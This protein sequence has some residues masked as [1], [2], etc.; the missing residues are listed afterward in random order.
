MLCGHDAQRKPVTYRQAFLSAYGEPLES[1][2]AES[3]QTSAE[4][5]APMSSGQI[6]P[7]PIKPNENAQGKLL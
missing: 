7:D 1:R 4:A 5:P 2:A 3:A 6:R